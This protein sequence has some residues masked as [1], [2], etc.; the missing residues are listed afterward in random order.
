MDFVGAT[1]KVTSVSS[2]LSNGPERLGDLALFAPA[3][4][5]V[6][7]KAMYRE[8]SINRLY[9]PAFST[10]DSVV[11]FAEAFDVDVSDWR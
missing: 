5:V 3:D 6:H 7:G 9:L 11:Q 8:G 2:R 10:E 1:G 4:L